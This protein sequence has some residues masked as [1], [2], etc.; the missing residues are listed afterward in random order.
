MDHYYWIIIGLLLDYY[1]LING[2]GGTCGDC[3]YVR[4]E[5]LLDARTECSVRVMASMLFFCSKKDKPKYQQQH[6][7]VERNL[8]SLVQTHSTPSDTDQ[9][10][11]RINTWLRESSDAS[12]R[13]DW[14]LFP[15]CICLQPQD[16]SDFDAPG[17]GLRDWLP[18][19]DSDVS[20]E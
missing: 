12:R 2:A 19:R 14:G 17:S 3:K 6:Q 9:L 7:L 20:T 1:W 10:R 5:C 16:I 8:L 4:I 13:H 11:H 15:C 18:R